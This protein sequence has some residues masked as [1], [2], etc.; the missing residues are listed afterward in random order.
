MNINLKN[1]DKVNERSEKSLPAVKSSTTIND[2]NNNRFLIYESK[3]FCFPFASVELT[4]A[5]LRELQKPPNVHA[6]DIA[7]LVKFINHSFPYSIIPV[8]LAE[9]KPDS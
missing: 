4:P 9:K 7:K 1:I 2:N 6:N 5:C 3:L 8:R